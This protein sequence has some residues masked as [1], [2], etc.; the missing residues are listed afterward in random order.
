MVD[1]D[2]SVTRVR[3][4][5]VVGGPAVEKLSAAVLDFWTFLFAATLCES[6]EFRECTDV[7]R[8]EM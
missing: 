8:V 6:G 3:L 1:R 4:A 2:L 7:H 5:F